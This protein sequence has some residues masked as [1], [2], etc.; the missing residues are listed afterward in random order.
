M[1]GQGNNFDYLTWMNAHPSLTSIKCTAPTYL[2]CP[3]PEWMTITLPYTAYVYDNYNFNFI[4]PTP[5]TGNGLVS[6][7]IKVNG[8][9]APYHTVAKLYRPNGTYL[10][11]SL[12]TNNNG[13]YSFSTST[14]YGTNRLEVTVY[15]NP[16]TVQN[17]YFCVNDA[18]EVFN[19]NLT[20]SGYTQGYVTGK[21]KNSCN[22][23]PNQIVY[24]YPKVANGMT[25]GYTSTN[26][27]GEYT[28]YNL[29]ANLYEF[30]TTFSG[31]IKLINANVTSGLLANQHFLFGL[32]CDD[33]LK[34]DKLVSIEKTE[35][36]EDF[37]LY[38][39]YPNPFN[40]STIIQY[41]LLDDTQV[42]IRV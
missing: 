38:Q 28:S 31:Q 14:P 35:I 36:P 19:P 20:I 37:T 4:T 1:C 23:V 6:G 26:S 30:K 42:K 40:P 15:T 39:N 22:A 3:N 24:F 10:G 33:D 18:N 17:F 9:S 11:Y 34:L 29:P 27:L 13:S 25:Q 41:Y 7:T 16:V 21:V 8:S 12:T 5:I 32:L 2:M